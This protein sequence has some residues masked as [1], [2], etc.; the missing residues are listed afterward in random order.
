[1]NEELSEYPSVAQFD[2]FLE[3]QEEEQNRVGQ[4]VTHSIFRVNKTPYWVVF[5]R[6]RDTFVISKGQKTHTMR[7]TL[8]LN[9]YPFRAQWDAFLEPIL[10]PRAYRD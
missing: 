6:P 2:A 3:P 8:T 10:R 7:I 9:G 5:R 4:I 1:M